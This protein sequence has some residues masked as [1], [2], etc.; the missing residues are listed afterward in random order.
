M[1]IECL[2]VNLDPNLRALYVSMHTTILTMHEE[3]N[4]LKRQ[5]LGAK[6]ERHTLGDSMEGKIYHAKK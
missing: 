1:N 2:P 6:S 5:L 3:I 4:R